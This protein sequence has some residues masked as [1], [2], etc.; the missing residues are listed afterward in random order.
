[1]KIDEYELEINGMNY[2]EMAEAPP[3]E[4]AKLARTDISFQMIGPKR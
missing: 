1:M 2:K 3:R 4:R